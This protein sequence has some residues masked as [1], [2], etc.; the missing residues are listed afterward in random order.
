[1]MWF[2][3]RT[4]TKTYNM[5]WEADGRDEGSSP[6]ILGSWFSTA[7]R[8]RGEFLLQVGEF[9]YFGVLFTSEELSIDKS[10]VVKTELNEKLSIYQ[11]FYMFLLS[12]LVIES[13]SWPKYKWLKY[14]F[15]AR[16]QSTPLEV[17]RV[18]QSSRK[19]SGW[20][21]FS[22][23]SAKVAQTSFLVAVWMPQVHRHGP[24]RA[25]VIHVPQLASVPVRR[26]PEELEEVSAVREV[27]CLIRLLP[28]QPRI[29]EM[30]CA[31]KSQRSKLSILRSFDLQK[32]LGFFF[33]HRLQIPRSMSSHQRMWVIVNIR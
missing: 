9:R 13:T 33:Y 17:W 14:T 29:C 15:S 30:R 7:K 22:Y 8:L 10:F 28:S 25:L 21:C 27:R 26:P 6:L 24:G 31:S 11:L 5:H 16:W 32:S 1:M 12:P 4:P 2:C 3:W 23:E 20:S 18:D 19:G